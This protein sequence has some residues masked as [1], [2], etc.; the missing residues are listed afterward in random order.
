M[1]ALICLGPAFGDAPFNRWTALLALGSI[2][3]PLALLARRTR[4]GKILALALFLMVVGYSTHAYLPIRAAQHPA[5]NEGNPS[6]WANFRDLL[7][8]KQYGQMNMFERRAPWSVQLNK[9]FWR[10]FSRQWPLFP[11]QRL[12]GVALPLLLGLAGGVWQSRRE[13]ISFLAQLHVMPDHQGR[14]IGRRLLA[15]AMDHAGRA[16]GMML[17]S[18]LD[19]QAMRCYSRAGFTLEPALQATGRTRRSLRVARSNRRSTRTRS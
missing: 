13:R 1:A 6:N 7:E 18:S 8:R 5:I 16:D 4:E 19:P 17:H 9:E 12:W 3:V 14:G 10:Y 15:A 2:G 11:T